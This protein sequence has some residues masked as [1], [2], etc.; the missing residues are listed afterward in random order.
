MTWPRAALLTVALL[1]GILAVTATAGVFGDPPPSVVGVAV[2]VSPRTKTSGCKLGPNPDRR[3]SPG[4]Y[5]SKLTKQVLCSPSFRTSSIRDVPQAERFAVEQEYGMKPA[6][7]GRTL[8]IDNIVGLEIGGSNDIA[9]LFPEKLNA[10]PGYPV[11][12]KLENKLHALVCSG[13]MTLRAAQRGIATNWQALYKRVFGNLPT[14]PPRAP[15]GSAYPVHTRIVATTFWVG[16]IF[17]ASIADGSQV[18]SAY[19]SK[20]AF[21]WSGGTNVGTDPSTDCKGAPVGGC[22]GRPSGT[23]SNFKCTTE[24]RQ[25]SNGYFPTSPLVHPAENP[26]YLDLPFDDINDSTAFKERCQVIPW[27]A[28]SSQ[29]SNSNYSYMK[30]HWVQIT[31]PN[32][33]TC[34]GQVEDAGPSH[35]SLYHDAAYVFGSKNVQPVQGQ[36]NNAGMDVSPALN[37]CLGFKELDGDTDKVSWGFVDSPPAGPWTRIITTRQVS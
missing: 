21:H 24:A 14:P 34:Y 18:C 13:E 7:Y 8:E 28:G 23:G 31:G 22:D 19:D 27:A 25:A 30:N 15:P 10:N 2:L 11:K 16:E 20:W 1:C 33:H 12:D 9:N 6:L 29:C 5:Y 35:G 36:F 4:A 32:G 3:C 26:F 37:G 17:N